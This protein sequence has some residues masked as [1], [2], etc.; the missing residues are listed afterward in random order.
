MEFDNIEDAT[1]SAQQSK[2]WFPF[3]IVIIYHDH[4]TKKYGVRICKTMAISN[5]LMREG[6]AVWLVS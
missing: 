6:K 3:R 1:K 5:R 2:G 4:E